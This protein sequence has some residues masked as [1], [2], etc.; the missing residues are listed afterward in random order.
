[1]RCAARSAA[2]R[3]GTGSCE[4]LAFRWAGRRWLAVRNKVLPSA[5][6]RPWCGQRGPSSL[7]LWSDRRPWRINLRGCLAR[8][9][10]GRWQSRSICTQWKGGRDSAGKQQRHSGS[11]LLTARNHLP[12]RAAGE[13]SSDDRGTRAHQTVRRDDRRQRPVV[14]RDAGQGDG[15]SRPERSGQDHD[16]EADPGPGLPQRRRGQDRRQAVR[17]P[18]L[19]HARGGRAARR[20]GGARRPFG[21]QPPALP[22]PDQQPAQEAGRRGA[23][24]GRPDRGGA[25]ARQGVLPGHVTAARHRRHPARRPGAC[26][27]STSRS[28]GWTRRGSCGSAT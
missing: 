21:L 12:G 25:Q 23:R 24:A 22:G 26:S 6:I 11:S 9:R 10:A 16:H 13:E 8:L 18:G 5:A 1:M 20:Q 27:C 15:L 4:P 2:V 7:R 19:P 17:E 3:P 28:T 14:R